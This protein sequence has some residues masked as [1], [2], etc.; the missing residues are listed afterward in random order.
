MDVDPNIVYSIESSASS[1]SIESGSASDQYFVGGIGAWPMPLATPLA[2][3]RFSPSFKYEIPLPNGLYNILIVMAE[4]NKTGPGQ[5]IFTI[6]ANAQTTSPIDLYALTR[7]QNVPYQVWMQ[8]LVGAGW[9][10]L[11]FSASVGSA[12][13]SQIVV[14]PIPYIIQTSVPNL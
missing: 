5:R 1:V 13:V 12:V 7:A 4:P 2:F 9:L 14:S 10:H 11:Q 6:T 8:A 3:L